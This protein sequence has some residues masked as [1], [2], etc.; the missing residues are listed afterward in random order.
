[1]PAALFSLPRVADLPIIDLEALFADLPLELAQVV[2]QL[3]SRGINREAILSKIEAWADKEALE[4]WLLPGWD[5]DWRAR[6]VLTMADAFE[7]EEKR[8]QATS[9]EEPYLLRR[10]IRLLATVLRARI[11]A[12]RAKQAALERELEVELAAN[13]G[14][15]VDVQST[16]VA[17]QQELATAAASIH[18]VNR[19]AQHPRRG[20]EG[21]PATRRQVGRPK[22]H[23]VSKQI[24]EKRREAQEPLA[25]TQ[26]AE[27][28]EII[29][30]W[31]SL[32]PPKPQ[33]ETVSSHISGLWKQAKEGRWLC[34]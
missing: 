23:L 22:A 29:S 1:M 25:S 13:Q 33:A 20:S 10:P 34:P 4:W 16:E 5:M 15:T 8:A 14:D 31:P 11:M 19:G 9:V 27:A 32:G 3:L 6:A 24:F 7:P 30:E 18:G 2:D 21:E 12:Q 17:D 28:K 26:S